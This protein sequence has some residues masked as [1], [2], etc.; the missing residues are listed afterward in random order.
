[1]N[2]LDSGAYQLTPITDKEMFL[3]TDDLILVVRAEIA[4]NLERRVNWLENEVKEYDKAI[5]W[6]REKLE[7]YE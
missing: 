2:D 1:M 6:Y 7:E 5:D 3:A 4:R